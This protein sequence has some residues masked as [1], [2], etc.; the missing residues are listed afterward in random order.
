[1]TGN[2]QVDTADHGPPIIKQY[3]M[4]VDK[5][6]DVNFRLLLS[7]SREDLVLTDGIAV[8]AL[9]FAKDDRGKNRPGA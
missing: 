4:T 2:T 6:V 3:F 7:N 5:E 8:V 9:Q 1:M